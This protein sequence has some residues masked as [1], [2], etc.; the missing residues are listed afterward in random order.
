MAGTGL[1]SKQTPPYPVSSSPNLRHTTRTCS[2]RPRSHPKMDEPSRA[3]NQRG[4]AVLNKQQ[5]HAGRKLSALPGQ[6]LH[7]ARSSRC[8]PERAVCGLWSVCPPSVCLLW[9]A[10][11]EFTIH[12]ST[13]PQKNGREGG[14]TQEGWWWGGVSFRSQT[15]WPGQILPH[16]KSCLRGSAGRK[17]GCKA[18]LHGAKEG[19]GRGA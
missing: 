14:V 9:A 19:P 12:S 13:R 16:Q 4:V 18:K 3:Q 15:G 6:C 10:E 5:P 11:M 1:K 2:K 7:T 17:W 8:Y